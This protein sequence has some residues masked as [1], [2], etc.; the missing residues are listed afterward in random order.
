MRKISTLL[1]IF[2]FLTT[3]VG[4][5]ANA[6]STA[7]EVLAISINSNAGCSV[8]LP[9]VTTGLFGQPTIFKA[10]KQE[11]LNADEIR[12][13][14][15]KVV[16]AIASSQVKHDAFSSDDDRVQIFAI[17]P[18]EEDSRSFEISKDTDLGQTLLKMCAVH[19]MNQP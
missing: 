7:P 4:I 3:F 15:E 12:E 5:S 11:A 19:H 17:V 1:T 16:A 6:Q 10:K 8:F 9:Q 18:G 13:L 14:N 2:G